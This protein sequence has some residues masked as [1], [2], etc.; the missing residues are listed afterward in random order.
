MATR[1][2][3]SPVEGRSVLSDNVY[4]VLKAH[5][6]DQ[7]VLAG[8]RLSIDGLARELEVSPTPV[9]EALTRLEAQGMVSRE[10]LRGYRVARVLSTKAFDELYEI[11]LLLEPRAARRAATHRSDD[12]LAALERAGTQVAQ[13][14]A[15][16]DPDHRTAERSEAYVECELGDAAFHEQVAIASDSELLRGTIVRLRP[17]LQLYRLPCE[18]FTTAT[19][20]EHARILDAI[21][22][23]D[24]DEAERAM[25]THIESSSRR[26]RPALLALSGDERS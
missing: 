4:E 11:R 20:D 3:L 1:I 21:A 8:E 13:A 25:V 12:H 15:Q 9:R 26:L 23:R 5:L 22:R 7:R 14:R 17:H 24:G 10:A 2:A 19:I 16:L 6:M 18:P